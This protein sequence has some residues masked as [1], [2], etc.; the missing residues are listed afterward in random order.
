ME[1]DWALKISRQISFELFKD[2]KNVKVLAEILLC[3]FVLVR[4]PR[5]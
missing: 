1:E 3:H 2:E 4:A 5:G